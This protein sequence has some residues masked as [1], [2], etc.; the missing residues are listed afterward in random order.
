MANLKLGYLLTVRTV[1]Y[2]CRAAYL[3]GA[4]RP[5]LEGTFL[6]FANAGETGVLA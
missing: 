4:Y 6:A 1:A 3:G 5:A 2:C